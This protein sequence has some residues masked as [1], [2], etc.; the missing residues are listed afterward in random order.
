MKYILLYYNSLYIFIPRF[1]YIA[2]ITS[3]RYTLYPS[4]LSRCCLTVGRCVTYVRVYLSSFL[5]EPVLILIVS[6]LLPCAFLINTIYYWSLTALLLLL[7]ALF[8]APL[9]LSYYHYLLL[10]FDSI[11]TVALCSL[12]SCSVN[13]WI[14]LTFYII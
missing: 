7:S 4:S 10:V 14:A 11:I 8:H 6:I 5:Y 9:C 2:Y 13:R 1:A 3:L 12:P